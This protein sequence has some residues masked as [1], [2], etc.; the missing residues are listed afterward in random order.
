MNNNN[1]ENYG[2]E[3]KQ[4]KQKKPTMNEIFIVPNK[5]KPMILKKKKIIKSLTK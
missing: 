1:F 2:S 4:K 5:L 3:E